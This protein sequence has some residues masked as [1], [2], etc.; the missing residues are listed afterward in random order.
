MTDPRVSEARRLA[1]MERSIEQI[2]TTLQGLSTL[3]NRHDPAEAAAERRELAERLRVL[4]L[5]D[6]KQERWGVRIGAVEELVKKAGEDLSY[7]RGRGMLITAGITVITSLIG[8][9]GAVVIF[10]ASRGG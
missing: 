4:E 2:L 6:A 8:T 10:F 5:A 9:L 1:H 7:Q 3:L